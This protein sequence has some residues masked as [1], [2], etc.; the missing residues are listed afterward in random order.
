MYSRA[1]LVNGKGTRYV[2]S[3]DILSVAANYAKCNYTNLMT[4]LNYID[5]LEKKV[6]SARYYSL[7]LSVLF[8]RLWCYSWLS[9]CPGTRQARTGSCQVC[10]TSRV[11]RR[12]ISCLS[13]QRLFLWKLAATA[14][15]R[16]L[17]TSHRQPAT[18]R[19]TELSISVPSRSDSMLSAWTTVSHPTGCR[20][21]THRMFPGSQ[22]SEVT[23]CA[24]ITQIDCNWIILSYCRKYCQTL[25]LCSTLWGRLAW[26]MVKRNLL[27]ELEMGDLWIEF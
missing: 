12:H 6:F 5:W 11:R 17:S 22:V 2:W 4:L 7:F 19:H 23:C 10:R 13:W 15:R 24:I 25:Y 3:Y 20:G 18:H 14:Q 16:C 8:C 21:P 1:S 26:D 9:M 27:L